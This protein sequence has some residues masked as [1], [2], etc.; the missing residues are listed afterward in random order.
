MDNNKFQSRCLYDR[1]SLGGG[2]GWF[3]LFSDYN[4]QAQNETAIHTNS[5]CPSQTQFSG[6]RNR[7]L[8][9][10]SLSKRH[11]MKRWK[12]ISSSTR[13]SPTVVT[14]SR[15][16]AAPLHNEGVNNRRDFFLCHIFHTARAISIR[17][18][19]EPPWTEHTLYIIQ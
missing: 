11:K 8:C 19:R 13:L 16:E 14:F 10:G 1:I 18:K 17:D 12:G 15:S 9:E 3:A 4:L 7:I 5:Q 2:R 6:P